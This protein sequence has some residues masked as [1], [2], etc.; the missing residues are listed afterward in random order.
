MPPT[1]RLLAHER[2]RYSRHLLLSQVGEAGQLRLK[3]ARVLCIGMG[4]LGSPLSL[5]LAA[6]G[7]GT[8]GLV[9]FDTV[10]G[11]NLQRQIVHGEADIGRPKVHSARDRLLALNP[12]INLEI[13]NTRLDAQNA[14]ALISAYD[15]I[16]DGAD[17]FATRYLVNDACVLAGRPN[18][19]ASIFRFEGRLSVF[20]LPE[21]PCYRCLHPTPPPPGAV[22]SCGEAGV[23]GILPGALGTLQATEVIKLLLGIGKPLVGRLLLYDALAMSFE[24]IGIFKHPR[25]PRC[26]D[27]PTLEGL[28]E[29]L[30][31]CAA[32]I[33]TPSTTPLEATQWRE[34]HLFLDVREAG[35]LA[36]C[37]LSWAQHIPLG[38]LANRLE[39]IPR[40]R[41]IVALCRSGVRSLTAQSLLL[42]ANF[43][44]VLNLEGGILR[45]AAEVDQTLIPY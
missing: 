32:P 34:S 35:E 21:G 3:N 33:S 19:H 14:M 39:E 24:E 25:C 8:L 15:V 17:N 13:H 23:L 43:P 26:S 1:D 30:A 7:V 6:A 44:T 4:G 20:G 29:E 42:E 36:I 37:S 31:V 28:E 16:A 40:D 11:S 9:D 5:Y 22:P 45:W 27:A 18:V 38:E 12:H 2:A 10:E 41:P